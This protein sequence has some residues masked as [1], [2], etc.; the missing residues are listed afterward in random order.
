[1][2]WMGGPVTLDVGGEEIRGI[3]AGI[4]DDGYLMLETEEGEKVY[5]SGDVSLRKD[6][7]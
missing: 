5:S 2:M 6:A 4:T 1:M 3:L 7:E